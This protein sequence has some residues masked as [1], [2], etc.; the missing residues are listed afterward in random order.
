MSV[1]GRNG[2]E[3]GAENVAKLVAYLHSVEALP[4]RNGQ[5][6]VT[7]VAVAAGLDRQALYKNPE[8]RRLL[9]ETIATKGLRGLEEKPVQTSDEGQLRLER[10]IGE[11]ERA[12]AALMAENGELRAK[13]RRFGH[14]E[15]HLI[16]TG[17]L[18]R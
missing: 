18:V 4:A 5:V 8:C 15:A 1:A 16:Q 3:I 9:E 13:V 6:N 11:L 10:R 7:A 14:I 2:A 17:R 12:N